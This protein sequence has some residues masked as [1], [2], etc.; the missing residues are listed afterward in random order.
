[1][2]GL[3]KLFEQKTPRIYFLGA[4]VFLMTAWFSTGYNHF[5]EHFQVIEFAGLKLGL[6][7]AA[8]LPW[9]YGC[10]MRPA[11]QPLA[12]VVL[13]RA[14]GLAGI[15]DPFLIAFIIRL[16]AALLT[17]WSIHLVIR[18][19][20]PGLH[21]PCLRHVLLLLSF[22]LWFIPYNAARFASETMAGRIF[23]VGMALLFLR[24]EQRAGDHLLNG[25]IL[26]LAF[27]FRYQA[28]FMIAGYFAWMALVRRTGFRNLASFAAGILLSVGAGIVIDRWFYGRWVFT[29][30]NYF[31]Q[32]LVEGK[33]ATFGTSP[34]WYYIEQTLV[35]AFPPLSLVLVAAVF[36]YFILFPKDIITWTLV[37]FLAV[38]F[39]IPH[40]EIRFLFPVIGFLPVMIVRTLDLLAE[41]YPSARPE[42]RPFRVSAKIFWF[43][44]TIMLVILVF[45]PADD[46]I[47]LF[48]TLWD[49]YD[50]PARLCYTGDNPYHRA[51]VDV[52]FYKRKSLVLQQVDSVNRI[53]PVRDT[54]T[55]VVTSRPLV[56]TGTSSGAELVYSTY[57]AWVRR[58]NIN[59]WLDRTSFW[60]VYEIKPVTP[61]PGSH[62]TE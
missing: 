39:L 42:R 1:M 50:R 7:E 55:L 30:W 18:L 20:S 41:R 23:L 58:F 34:W 24:R 8:N 29:S 9:E 57:P 47:A 12:V 16:F 36:L 2:A 15:S 62:E 32:N 14:A 44:N 33:A 6:T 61:S 56:M 28:G 37:P 26:G 60:H 35:N 11:I 43:L 45:R 53:R 31:A 19:Y 38:H 25:L 10:M 40:K 54:V 5:D 22:F 27:V 59:H 4:V 52:H 48:K 13:Y 49:R 17:F 21:N 46:G 3:V 51:K